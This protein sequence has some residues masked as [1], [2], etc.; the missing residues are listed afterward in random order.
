[1]TVRVTGESVTVEA[2]DPAIVGLAR[3]AVEALGDQAAEPGTI[4]GALPA[5]AGLSQ[6]WLALRDSLE[7]IR[8]HAAGRSGESG[9][10]EGGQDKN[11]P[12][13]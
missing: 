7:D 11:Q 12:A 13:A 4:P 5:G 6:V 1:M 9:G 2:T 8:E 10:P 3:A